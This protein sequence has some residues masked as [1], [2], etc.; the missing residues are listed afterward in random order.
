MLRT[1]TPG[2]PHFRCQPTHPS[3]Q[4]TTNSALPTTHRPNFKFHDSLEG[5]T[6]LRKGL[7][8]ILSF[9]KKGYF[10]TEEF[11]L[12]RKS[13]IKRDMGCGRALSAGSSVPV[14]LG[15]VTFP[16]CG[17]VHQPGSPSNPIT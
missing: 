8:S 17:C 11:L 7:F 15:C 14:D 16:A 3:V 12:Q 13:Q 5:L 1:Q 6:E 2:S 10:F 4:L 9:F